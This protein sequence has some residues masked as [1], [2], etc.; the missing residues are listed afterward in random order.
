MKLDRALAASVDEPPARRKASPEHWQ[1]SMSG[2]PTEEPLPSSTWARAR[3]HPGTGLVSRRGDVLLVVPVLRR[4]DHERVRR[5]VELCSRPDPAGRALVDE[6]RELLGASAEVPGFALL[7]RAGETLRTVVHGPV[8]ILVDGRVP[9]RQPGGA[10]LAEHVLADGAW[11][12]LTVAAGGGRGRG[13][14]TAG[15]RGPALDLESG[16]VPGGGL[17]LDHVPAGR[18][19]SARGG[20]DSGGPRDGGLLVGALVL[21]GAARCAVP[22]GPARGVRRPFRRSF[23]PAGSPPPLPVAGAPGGATVG[24]GHGNRGARGGGA[25]PRRALHGPGAVDVPDVRDA[26]AARRAPGAEAGTSAG[27]RRH[28]R[29]DGL[30]GDR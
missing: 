17:T 24:A 15:R 21:D 20:P 14:G 29:R 6:L 28:R 13:R 26:A 18:P 1:V 22:D 16:T 23:G 12:R 10:A 30:P 5:L 3:V 2:F 4:A 8:R 27:R 25:L 11:H 7:V 9:E 19:A